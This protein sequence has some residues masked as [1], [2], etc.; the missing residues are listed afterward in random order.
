MDQPHNDS[1]NLFFPPR[2]ANLNL[3]E[4]ILQGSLIVS[5]HGYIWPLFVGLSLG[6]CGAIPD[7]LS[8]DHWAQKKPIRG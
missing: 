5:K 6:D 4:H 7:W 1:L 3:S 2:I 8:V